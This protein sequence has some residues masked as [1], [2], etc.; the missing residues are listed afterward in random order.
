[1][2][3]DPNLDSPEFAAR[4]YTLYRDFFDRAEKRRRWSLDRDIPWDECNPGLNPAVADVVESFCAVEL[5]LPDYMGKMLPM[6]R[7]SRGR[8]WF[9]FNW[10][11]EESK[12]SLA[13]GDW[14]L[15]SGRRS[16]EHMVDLENR[17][18]AHEW[19]LPLDSVRGM[20]CYSMSQEL[21]TWL[22]YRNLRDVVGKDGDPALH[23]LLGFILVDER[24]HY[25][26]FRKV[27]A[28][29]L[30]ADRAGTLE[31]MRRVLNQFHMPAVYSLA[32]GPQRIAAVKSLNIF[33]DE[34]FYKDVYQ[35][36][37]ADLGI[38]RA[39]MRNRTANRKSV[40]T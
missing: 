13:L 4:I 10:G 32:D 35:V 14:L 30:E 29:H 9:S 25:D 1:M 26:F 21:A 24:A 33:N 28:M 11:Y 38:E 40:A 39:E 17:I 3:T 20:A 19:N 37:L 22:N 36:I 6:I 12:H 31:Q 8:S 23:R 27:V 7:A 16:E 34:Y 2:T 18:F 15:K 5:Y